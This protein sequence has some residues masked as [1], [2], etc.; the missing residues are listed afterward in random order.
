MS[1]FSLLSR[2]IQEYIRDKGWDQPRPIQDVAIRRIIET[3]N[4]YI[5]SSK[6]A[7]G[8]TEAAFLPVLTLA[9]GDEYRKGAEGYEEGVRV[10]YISPLIALINDQMER[11]EDLCAYLG[12]PVTKWHGE[13]SASAKNRIIRN[14][15]G[16]VLMTP[17]SLEAMFQNKP[18]N[19]ARLFGHLDFVI[20]DEIHYFLGTDRGT[21]L[22]SLLERL[23]QECAKHHEAEYKPFR[24]VGLSAT[25]GGDMSAA[26]GF[27][28]DPER[29]RVLVDKGKRVTEVS[30]RY[31]RR[32][33][34]GQITEQFYDE[35]YESTK[36]LQSLVFPNSRAKVEVMANELK[37]RADDDAVILAHHASLTRQTREEVESTVKAA[38]G[39]PFTICC[40]ST[41]ELGIDL[42]SVDKICQ[43]ESVPSVSS[44][45]QRTGRSGRS[46]G[47]AA[48]DLFCTLE[49]KLLRNVACWNL[50]SEGTVEAPDDK[51]LWYNVLVHQILSIVT[52]TTEETAA[53]RPA[54]DEVVDKV[55]SIPAFSFCTR[56]ECESI[57]DHLM[58][59]DI[60]EDV[61]GKMAIGPSGSC[62]VRKV[63]SYVVFSTPFNYKVYHNGECMGELEPSVALKEKY[64]FMLAAR[65]WVI[66]RIDHDKRLID[67]EISKDAKKPQFISEVPMTAMEVEQEMK[68]VLLGDESFGYLKEEEAAVLEGL[69]REL[70]DFRLLGDA[71]MP[72]WTNDAGFICFYPFQG[73]RVSNTLALLLGARQSDDY[74]LSIDLSLPKFLRRCKALL[75]NPPSLQDVLKARIEAKQLE[76]GYKYIDLLPVELQAKMLSTLKYDMEA[77][78]TFLGDLCAGVEIPEGDDDIGPVGGED[79]MDGAPWRDSGRKMQGK[80]FVYTIFVSEDDDDPE[81]NHSSWDKLLKAE[82]WLTAKAREYGKEITFVNGEAGLEHT[83]DHEIAP[84]GDAP[85][86]W[87]YLAETY[88]KA[89]GFN[90][91]GSFMNWVYEEHGCDRAAIVIMAD[92][93][94]R[95]Y[96]M[97]SNKRS[98]KYGLLGCTMIYVHDQHEDELPSLN[99]HELLHLFGAMDLY[100]EVQGYENAAFIRD[101]YPGE[102]MQDLLPDVNRHRMCPMTAWST[103]LSDKQEEW[104]DSFLFC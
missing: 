12:V 23:R 53:K 3:D 54:K 35:V 52:E 1:A 60:L 79:A 33:E 69:R 10:L 59:K 20:I 30:F 51:A 80:V 11:M 71:K 6:T 84:D 4:D 48:V 28:G 97:W 61:S 102:I 43:I 16:V 57:V 87:N 17:E 98:Q 93:M 67:V 78:M 103:W 31:V 7:S 92:S 38:D 13:A 15:E 29:T 63:N 58:A 49:W 34:D 66:V 96:A 50:Y 68:R 89:A 62:L 91:V 95:S 100:A 77:T 70:A 55:L 101:N 64:C 44:L 88:L 21:H 46:S 9:Y 90:S 94:G 72:Y 75:D 19:I 40:T 83:I 82:E 39:S 26:K 99:A 18:E 2:E 56:Q 47:K 37:A 25:I 74:M 42:P 24:W 36:G 22:R 27:L 65:K 41:L 5:L 32:D 8:K 81:L 14:P 104:F 86:Q 73:T 45:A 85:Y 76:L